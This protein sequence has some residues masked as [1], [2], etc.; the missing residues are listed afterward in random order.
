MTAL[1]PPPITSASAGSSPAAGRRLLAQ[2]GAADPV[3][4][5]ELTAADEGRLTDATATALMDL[6]RRDRD[7]EA[8]ETLIA[9]VRPRMF[10]RVRSRIRCL[11]ASMD[12]H[13]VLQDVVINVYRYPDRFDGRRPGAFR[14]WSSTIVDNTIRRHL[15]RRKRGAEVQLQPIEILSNAPCARSHEPSR[16]AETSE[17]CRNA[18]G[19]MQYFLVVY[20]D[21]YRSL[22]DRERFVLQ[23]VEVRGMRYAQL[24]EVLGIRPEALKMVVF[25]A[26]RRIADRIGAFFDRVL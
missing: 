10:A 24:A 20:L 14:A 17:E 18:L 15:R 9:L 23:M 13:E 7:D 19:A 8:F 12:P 6:Y 2:R 11:G 4:R 3:A 16:R 25:R 5:Y 1:T 26:R 22:S 21:A